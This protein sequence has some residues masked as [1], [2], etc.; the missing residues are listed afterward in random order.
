MNR[1]GSGA[2]I[3][4]KHPAESLHAF[5]CGGGQPFAVSWLD[6]SVVEPLV[7]PLAVIMSRKLPSRLPKRPLPEEDHPIETF[8]LDRP[9]ES[10]GVGVQVGRARTIQKPG[11]PTLGFGTVA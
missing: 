2:A 10:L 4:A 7:I 8:I 9:D 11:R 1:L 3:E 5:D 6:Q